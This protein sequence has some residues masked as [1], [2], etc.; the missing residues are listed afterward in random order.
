[1][2]AS[3]VRVHTC[4]HEKIL[5]QASKLTKSANFNING[6]LLYDQLFHSPLLSIATSTHSH[7]PSHSLSLAFFFSLSSH[8]N[9]ICLS[10]SFKITLIYIFASFHLIMYTIACLCVWHFYISHRRKRETGML[11]RQGTVKQICAC[12]CAEM[13]LEFYEMIHSKLLR[14]L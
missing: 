5:Q 3:G 12:V 2:R 10:H 11:K 9:V 14:L 4:E 7:S 8:S 6:L 1:M 13:F